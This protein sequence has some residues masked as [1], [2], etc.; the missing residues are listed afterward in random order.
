MTKTEE[1]QMLRDINRIA[2]A[3]ESISKSIKKPIDVIMGE[4]EKT[5]EE[6][7]E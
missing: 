3:L 2:R 7:R 4:P 5:D 1:K 6:T